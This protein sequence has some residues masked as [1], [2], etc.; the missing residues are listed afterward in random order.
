MRFHIC[1]TQICETVQNQKQN[2]NKIMPVFQLKNRIKYR[3]HNPEKSNYSK[4]NHVI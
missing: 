4:F 1:V 2:K 3:K